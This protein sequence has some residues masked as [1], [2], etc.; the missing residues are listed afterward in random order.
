M[1]RFPK[2]R[3]QLGVLFKQFPGFGFFLAVNTK[4]GQKGA[5]LDPT[6]KQFRRRV[7]DKT[8]DVGAAKRN[9]ANI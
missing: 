6:Q 9:A 1:H 5:Q 2:K 4:E 7:A 3:D 8:A